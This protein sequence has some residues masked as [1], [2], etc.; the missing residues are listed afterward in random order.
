MSAQD[1]AKAE[2]MDL[3]LLDKGMAFF[4]GDAQAAIDMN[5]MRNDP[6]YA[7]EVRAANLAR[8]LDEGTYEAIEEITMDKPIKEDKQ[9]FGKYNDQIK[10]IKLP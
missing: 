8:P 4:M 9:T 6:E 5:K 7:A 3:S 10:N 1:Q 2:G